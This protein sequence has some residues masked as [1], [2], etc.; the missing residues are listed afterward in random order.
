M[1]PQ[2]RGLRLQSYVATL[3]YSCSSVLKNVNSDL[4]N[5]FEALPYNSMFFI[6]V[7]KASAMEA[8]ALRPSPIARITVEGPCTMS[9]PA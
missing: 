8:A 9:P 3:L 6:A 4:R 1:Q 5:C 7:S 2:T